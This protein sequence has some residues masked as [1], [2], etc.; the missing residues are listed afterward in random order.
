MHKQIHGVKYKTHIF[1]RSFWKRSVNI[2]QIFGKSYNIIKE[3]RA[4][5][6]ILDEVTN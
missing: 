6:E 3:V 4:H 2:L 5:K 1:N